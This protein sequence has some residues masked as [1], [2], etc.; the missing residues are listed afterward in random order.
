M[1]DAVKTIQLLRPNHMWSLPQTCCVCGNPIIQ[2]PYVRA[3][4]TGG[5]CKTRYYHTGC[6]PRDSRPR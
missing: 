3:K 4:K 2:T 5:R 1:S 6:Y